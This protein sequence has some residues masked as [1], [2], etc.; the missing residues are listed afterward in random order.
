MKTH[1]T[2]RVL[3]AV[4]LLAILGLGMLGEWAMWLLQGNLT[5]GIYT[6]Q[7]NSFIVCN[8]FA[9][10]IAAL[11]VLV[12]AVGLFIDHP[13]GRPI[14]FIGGGMV[15]YATII[16]LGYTL[17]SEPALTPMLIVSLAIVLT[18]FALLRSDQAITQLKNRN[19]ESQI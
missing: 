11:L 16:G 18:C 8:I 4:I 9:D 14:T 1:R 12:G 17:Q 3:T 15:I 13:W 2:W 7:N 5:D 6:V 10:A 19:A